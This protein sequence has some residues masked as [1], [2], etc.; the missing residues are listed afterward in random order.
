[1][2]KT[3][4]WI[5]LL[6][7]ILAKAQT[8]PKPLD[9]LKQ[10]RTLLKRNSLL[11]NP[12]ESFKLYMTCALQGNA[13]A[14]NAVG[15]MY[16]SG[17]GTSINEKEGLSWLKKAAKKGYANAWYNLGLIYKNGTQV[18][19]DF[20]KA[21]DCF[22]KAAALNSPEAFYGQ[23]FMLYKGLGCPQ[24]YTQA[25]Q[26]FI[27]GAA[28]GELGSMYMLGL[29]YRNGYGTS[30][31]ADS[32]KYY[33]SLAS[34]HGYKFANEEIA[35]AQPENINITNVVDLQPVTKGAATAGIKNGYHEVKHQ[36]SVTDIDGEYTGY[37]IKF[38]W[39]GK[40]IINQS[41]LKLNLTRKGKALKG[42][43]AEEGTAPINIDGLLT[44]SA[45]VF[46]NTNYSRTDHYDVKAPNEFEFRD[47][48]L[49]LVKTHDTVFIA[50]TIRLYSTKLR[51][52][53]KPTYI[54]LIRTGLHADSSKNDSVYN[55]KATLQ[56]NSDSVHFKAY[57]N[58]FLQV[59]NVKYTLKHACT[60]R[61]VVS[62][63]L[64]AR[65]IYTGPSEQY[66]AGDHTSQVIISA[67]P[68]TYVV[69]LNY[70][71]QITSRIVFKQ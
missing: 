23:G 8:P 30:I 46:Q 9:N 59:L 13:E 67:P 17:L 54:M 44:D 31:N 2:K 70:G 33:L 48:H 16:N 56:S 64:N 47:S 14:M 66:E 49:Q 29:C 42:V 60:I 28:L 24:S 7:G 26:S 65:V 34:A 43:W 68:G 1:M 63:L 35:S 71:N 5:L 69:T 41:A 40:H 57:P 12:T 10:A 27:R 53:E 37:A 22:K 18:D 20:N 51:E 3:I 6:C 25:K 15:L 39:S 4:L 11:Y 45:L 50:S 21:Y 19:Q 52:P 36:A 55:L 38:D 32:A 62:D 61:I 58:P